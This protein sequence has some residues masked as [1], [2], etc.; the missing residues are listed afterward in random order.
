MAAP[1][2][3][4]NAVSVTLNDFDQVFKWSWGEWATQHTEDMELFVK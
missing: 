2:K 3:Q 4:S 1:V